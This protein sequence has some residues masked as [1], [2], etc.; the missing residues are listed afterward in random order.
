MIVYKQ[1]NQEQLDDQYNNRLHVPGFAAYFDRWDQ[2]SAATGAANAFIKDLPYGDDARERLDIFPSKKANAK[3]LVFIH[4]G[5]WQMFDKTK[6]HFVADSFLA[7][8]ITTVFI[9]YPLAPGA[10]MDMIVASCRK[11]LL[12]LQKNGAEY[13][14]DPQ[15]VCIAGHSAGGHLAVMLLEKEWST[16]L[17]YPLKGICA[18]SGLYNLRPIQL[19]YL[20]KALQMDNATAIRNSPIEIE[21]VHNCPVIIVTGT[22]ETNEFKDQ[23]NT[24][25]SNWKSKGAA[26]EI[27]ELTGLNHFSIAEALGEE[28]SQV[29]KAINSMLGNY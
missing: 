20:N 25:Y 15:Q 7:K 13:N 14:C 27:I 10:T 29:H 19:S 5:Y 2:Q 22:A 24:F 18:I 6:F 17:T 8:D 26:V 3:T 12:W 23:G 11:A 4:G 21:P 16:N 1:Y 28:H 9:N